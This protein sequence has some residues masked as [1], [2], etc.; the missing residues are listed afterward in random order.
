MHSLWSILRI[1]KK[2]SVT[3]ACKH[4]AALLLCVV[5]VAAQLAALPSALAEERNVLKAAKLISKQQGGVAAGSIAPPC[6]TGV[7]TS[8]EGALCGLSQTTES[9]RS[10][11]AYL[12]I[13]FGESTAGTR[14]WKAPQASAAWRGTLMATQFGP[15]CPQFAVPNP[16]TPQTQAQ[17]ATQ[18]EDCLSLNVWTPQG[19]APDARLPVMV[20]IYGGS[21]AAGAS[22]Y[23]LYDGAYLAANKNVIIVS[24]N[25]RVGVLGFLATD[26]L[27]GNYGFMD[28][29]LALSWVQKNIRGFG[30][31]PAKVTIFGESAG[32]MSVGLHVFSA[33]GS[34]RLFRAAI[35][36]SNFLA[37]PYKSLKDQINV[38]NI[39]KQ[40][41]NCADEICLRA[42]SVNDLLLAQNSFVPQ[43]SI[44]FSGT[45]YYIPF[46][47]A[48]DGKLLREQPMVASARG[49]NRKP[50]LIG[51]NKNEALLFTENDNL[52]YASYA[53]NV[54]SLFGKDFEAVMERYRTDE[55][56]RLDVVW[57]QVQTDNL[58]ICAARR[59]A[60]EARAPAY[61]YLF[62][63][64]PSFPVWGGPA[65]RSDDNVCHGDEL[66]F[67]FHS[68]D[69]IGGKFTPPEAGL[70][71]A[72]GTYWTNFAR[73]LDPNGAKGTSTTAALP[74]WPVFTRQQRRY[75]DLNLPQLSLQDDPYH[76][77]CTFWNGIG[78]NLV[79]PW[80][81]SRRSGFPGK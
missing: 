78:Y 19:A 77:I 65:C 42:T 45:K 7:M 14:R 66:P 16:P 57:G 41:L 35:M 75:M 32:A 20:Y 30:G 12:G 55:P 47:P 25:Y 53:A 24:F 52:D 34:K 4:G 81:P 31:D 76:D 38:G 70:S 51:T 71:D 60:S 44:V 68:A 64:Q 48:I 1:V 79:E 29:Q 80:A 3:A 10:A 15:V 18:S 72:M 6:T 54:A 23:P 2:W 62:N 40:G 21:F 5:A 27:R 9:G 36:E 11:N 67:V 59:M 49:G 50:I 8:K 46:S 43:M 63:H 61:A 58:L 33:P 13:P 17:A 56:S 37:L 28:Q 26:S 39:F 74:R 22:S 73:D 69:Q